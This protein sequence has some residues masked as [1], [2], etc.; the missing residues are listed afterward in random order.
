[1]SNAVDY[2]KRLSFDNK[3]WITDLK[4]KI[5]QYGTYT[6]E[7]ITI[8]VSHFISS[9]QPDNIEITQSTTTRTERK[10]LLYRF[11]E[12][13]NISGLI[14]NQEIEF[15]PF[16]TLIYG[17]NGSGKSSYY[18]AL[19]HIFLKN[20]NIR[21]NIY[22][23]TS[24]DIS[25]KIDLISENQFKKYQRK[26][27]EQF[28]QS[29]QTVSWD[30]AIS[31]SKIKFCDT[32]ILNKSLSKKDT[33]WSVDRY[34]LDYYETFREAIEK[35][36]NKI[37]NKIL[38]LTSEKNSLIKTFNSN[39]KSK[40]IN[41]I[42]NKINNSQEIVSEL[43]RINSITALEENF[44][45]QKEA[46][47]LKS[48][49]NAQE[50]S[51]KINL[52][53]DKIK[54][55]ESFYEYLGKKHNL[56][57]E[58]KPV[59]KIINKLNELKEKRDFSEFNSYDLI[60]SLEHEQKD[61]YI[62]LLKAIVKTAEKYELENYPEGINKCFYCNQTLPDQ[63]KSLIQNI[64]KAVEDE[65]D[66]DIQIAQKA[67]DTQMSAISTLIAIPT[68]IY[69]SLEI[70]EVYSLETK[71]V[72]DFSNILNSSIL[73][74]YK[75]CIDNLK[76][77]NLIELNTEMHKLSICLDIIR[78]NINLES[79]KLT[80]LNAE[81]SDFDILKT[82]AK[83]ELDSLLDEEYCF[84]NLENFRL[85]KEKINLISKYT[86]ESRN[87]A[88]YKAKLSR[89][90]SKVEDNLLRSNYIEAFNTHLRDFKLTNRDKINRSF[91]VS[92]GQTKI[93]GQIEGVSEK[94]KIEDVLSE[95]EAKV[96]TI[97]DW[98]TELEFDNINT[99]IFDDPITSLD[100][101]NIS[102][103]AKK[104]CKLANDYQVII[105]THNM[106]FYKYLVDYS[107]GSQAIE[108]VTCKICSEL[109]GQNQCQG[110]KP[111][112]NKTYKCGSYYKTEHFRQP[113]TIKKEINYNTLNY[114]NKLRTIKTRLE[115]QDLTD[116]VVNL[117]S[118][119]NDFVEQYRFNNIKR[120]IFKGEDLI[121][122][123]I[124]EI[125][126]EGLANLKQYHHTLSSS[127]GQLHSQDDEITTELDASDYIEIYN[128]IIDIINSEAHQSLL[129][130]NI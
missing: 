57:N 15:S 3:K 128:S 112:E 95:G 126:E 118:V 90:K 102:R 97:C 14:D 8:A 34:K 116:V 103:L 60:F 68:D 30:D 66:K 35:V 43:N 77:E 16:F 127:S 39:L 107:L 10:K 121:H 129:K 27:D 23:D 58:L 104:I 63:S 109:D 32:E 41:S 28:P 52:I 130:I 37:S 4:N 40:E 17:K 33:G 87:F 96:Y 83:K 61:I 38:E 69:S 72:Y 19:K 124:K 18:K 101:N 119:I 82:K 105:F 111:N 22:L 45:E 20:Q 80:K 110:F 7:D 78:S 79:M 62:N 70:Q 85:L 51:S 55:L 47:V 122:F 120:S 11:Y 44:E 26:G 76:A 56:Y 98:F 108:N 84:N 67:L 42:F 25:A 13:K 86:T 113:G 100:H 65:L 93:D 53:Q 9:E 59:H 54:L 74:N 92:S 99:I 91:S 123:D 6:D 1:M 46:L 21:P 81:L 29:I 117:R 31:S 106:E 5:C 12:N 64:H 24:D 114:I 125:T 88:T 75:T 49:Q 2:L 94:Y 115:N 89:D 50:L 48:T 73:E 71:T 36:N